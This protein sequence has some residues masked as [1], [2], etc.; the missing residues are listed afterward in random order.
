ME[1]II[2]K[3][4]KVMEEYNEKYTEATTQK[5]QEEINAEYEIKISAAEQVMETE[6]EEEIKKEDKRLEDEQKASEKELE[7]EEKEVIL[8]AEN[9]LLT[10]IRELSAEELT[11]KYKIRDANR[12]AKLL[13]TS[14]PKDSETGK[15]VKELEYWKHL[16]N[17]I[18]EIQNSKS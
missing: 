13:K 14:R 5:E 17:N 7:E 12:A 8:P 11:K 18:N 4:E 10:E 15:V 3:F 1:D 2:A 9:N 6:F 16:K